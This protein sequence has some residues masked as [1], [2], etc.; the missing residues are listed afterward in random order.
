VSSR[1]VGSVSESYDVPDE[2]KTS[3]ILAM[4]TT[5][6]YGMKFL[7]LALPNM[8]GNMAGLYGGTNP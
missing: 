7:Q 6:P 8:V 3:P 1:S 5:T 4:Y 2:Y